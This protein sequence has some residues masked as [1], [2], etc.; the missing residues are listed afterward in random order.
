M[1]FPSLWLAIGGFLGFGL[2]LGWLQQ[3]INKGAAD[4]TRNRSPLPALLLNVVA[5]LSTTWLFFAI[6]GSIQ[7]PLVAGA[8]VMLLFGGVIVFMI[9]A[10]A[11]LLHPFRDRD[12]GTLTRAFM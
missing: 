1:S 11:G 4:N 10:A 3:T 9:Y 6:T 7:W 5:F 12:I 2:I 8:I